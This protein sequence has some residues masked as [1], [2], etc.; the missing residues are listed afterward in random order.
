[1]LKMKKN[2]KIILSLSSFLS[3]FCLI[4]FT[5]TAQTEEVLLTNQDYGFWSSITVEKNLTQRIRT[6]IEQQLRLNNY[7]SGFQSTFTE[8]GLR[9]RLTDYFRVGTSYRFIVRPA[10]MNHRISFYAI[11]RFQKQ[12]FPV[13]INNRI[14][15]QKTFSIAPNSPVNFVRNKFE[16]NYNLSRL[17]DP[18]ITCEL[19][20]RIYNKPDEIKKYRIFFGLEWRID[21]RRDISTFYLFQR[22][23]NVN[24]PEFDYILSISFNYRLP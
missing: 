21:G 16:L 6:D 23:V 14:L 15:Y 20:Y 13:R 4:V 12:N 1:M 18:F 2:H 7:V 3:F 11:L 9:Y 19:F 5:A 10:E 22:E 8:L 24:N 17:V